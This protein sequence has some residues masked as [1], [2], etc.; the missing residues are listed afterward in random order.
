MS[1]NVQ[2]ALVALLLAIVG[3]AAGG[4]GS[5]LYLRNLR[6]K[7]W[8]KIRVQH[9]GAGGATTK[10][11]VVFD[12]PKVPLQGV[13]VI[14]SP[15]GKPDLARVEVRGASELTA[16]YSDDARPKSFEA[17]NG[18]K[19]LIGYKGGKARLTFLNAD[20]KQVGDKVLRVPVELRSALK[21]ASAHSG[22]IGQ[23]WAQP[24]PKEGERPKEDPQINVQREVVVALDIS[25]KKGEPGEAEVE[26]TCAQ[27][28]TCLPLTPKVKMPGQ[29]RV[30]IGVTGAKQQSELKAPAGGS[31][32][33]SFKEVAREERSVAADVLDDVARVI[34]AVG[35]ANAAC[36]AL[37]LQSKVCAVRM[38]RRASQAGIVAV[39]SH[40]VSTKV[41]II[42][43]R[44]TE[45]YYQEQ[46]RAILDK[47]TTV[48]VCISRNG[49]TR[50]CT[51]VK[52]N[53][54]GPAPMAPV[55]RALSVRKGISGTLVGS[56]EMTQSDG[57]DCKFSPSPKTS[58]ALR[59]SFDDKTGKV[60]AKLGA[61][62]R[63]TRNGLRCSLG[64]GDMRW[65]QNYS[66]TMT[67]TFSKDELS[68]GG[69]LPLNMRGT[70]SGSGGSSQSNCRASSGA[71]ANCPG[72]RNKTYSYSIT[73][74]GSID[75]DTQKGSGRLSVS[76]APLSTRGSW[77]IGKKK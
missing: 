7:P 42:D 63:G 62:E 40:E 25:I 35:L 26:A 11:R 41:H 73:L 38:T 23:A 36:Q 34:A 2:T 31:A 43:A 12:N 17:Q 27:P 76:G 65:H 56:F 6:A 1:R 59:L 3:F 22:L 60:T 67:Q 74:S 33:S 50:A 68:G 64:S 69:K 44:A 20:G 15:E 45:L 4:M 8:R 37:S 70:M 72:P 47:K 19:V 21:Q 49:Y 16:G 24:A 51:K 58:G 32:P 77:Q 28:F 30:R 71:A 75:L 54:L 10:T 29:S 53:P 48:E 5:A 55:S 52:G 66:A 46:A 61:N 39:T 14:R 13:E 57:A 18:A 9:E